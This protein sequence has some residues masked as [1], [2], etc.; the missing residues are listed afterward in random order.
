[1][2]DAVLDVIKGY[3]DGIETRDLANVMFPD[4]PIWERDRY[5]SMVYSKLQKLQRCGFVESEL[6]PAD[7]GGHGSRLWR[8]AEGTI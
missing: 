2:I 8:L 5:R 7:G 1:M 4:V 6:L 3:P